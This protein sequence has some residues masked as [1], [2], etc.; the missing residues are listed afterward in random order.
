MGADA[1]IFGCVEVKLEK[2]VVDVGKEEKA[3]KKGAS[4]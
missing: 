1:C 3:T 4:P 2:W